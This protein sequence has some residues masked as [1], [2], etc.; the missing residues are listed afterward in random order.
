[1]VLVGLQGAITLTWLVDN[2]YLPQLL[3]QF[4]FP[5]SLAA[6]LM[7]IENALAVVM[8]ALM[9]DFPLGGVSVQNQLKF[10]TC[11]PFISIDVILSST[12]FV[13]IPYRTTF[14]P[15]SELIRRTLPL[16]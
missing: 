12:L 2:A 16:R 10:G 9:G 14:V 15:P 13:A 7:V 1:L 4:G 6:G 11:F 3:T 8:E 5:A